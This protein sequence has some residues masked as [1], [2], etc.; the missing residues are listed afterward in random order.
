MS[1]CSGLVLSPVMRPRL[2]PRSRGTPIAASE[3]HT[4]LPT[5]I[6]RR[7]A[8]REW[9]TLPPRARARRGSGRCRGA[10]RRAGPRAAVQAIRLELAPFLERGERPAS[11]VVGAECVLEAG[12]GGAGVNQEG[13]ADLADVAESLHRRACRAGQ[14][15]A[16]ESDIVPERIAD[17]LQIG[18][19]APDHTRGP[20]AATPSGASA[21]NCSKFSRNIVASLRAW[22]S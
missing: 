3:S 11:Q 4:E 6:W 22:V 20:A 17:D 8:S 21:R 5:S 2:R 18:R 13:V 19:I 1:P 14:R 15:R 16:V 12:M 9:G 10:G 7:R